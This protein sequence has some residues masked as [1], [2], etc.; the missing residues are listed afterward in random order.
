[1]NGIESAVFELDDSPA[2]R[3]QGGML[4]IHEDSGQPALHAAGLYEEFRAL[5]HPGGEATRVLD[6]AATVLVD[7]PDDDRASGAPRSTAASCA[8]CCS[9]RCP[10]TRSA[11]AR[12][13]PAS[14]RSTAAGTR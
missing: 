6:R 13:S 11:G 5:V 4:D 7:N 3:T 14:A 12:R 1:M 9:A 10:R 8:I 2:A